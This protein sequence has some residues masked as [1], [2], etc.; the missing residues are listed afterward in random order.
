M[1]ATDR[2]RVPSQFPGV[3]SD[4]LRAD[5]YST[6]AKLGTIECGRILSVAPQRGRATATEAFGPGSCQLVI[7]GGYW[8]TDAADPAVRVPLTTGLTIQVYITDAALAVRG[9]GAYPRWRRAVPRFVGTITD[10]GDVDIRP[11]NP[12][13][14]LC[15]I[16]C[17]TARARFGNAPEW[18]LFDT[19]VALEVLEADTDRDLLDR[20]LDQTYAMDP[21]IGA[22]TA[23]AASTPDT[24]PGKPAIGNPAL[25]PV[26]ATLPLIPMTNL[27]AGYDE[28]EGKTI[29]DVL[30]DLEPATGG[31]FF[32]SRRGQF[33]WLIPEE[34]RNAGAPLVIDPHWCQTPLTVRQG[35]GDVVNRQ[36]IGFAVPAGFYYEDS[37]PESIADRGHLPGAQV[38]TR[39]QAT[40]FGTDDVGLTR[41]L[42][43]A[44]G[45]VG[46]YSV[47]AWTTPAVTIDLTR[48][49]EAGEDTL[50]LDLLSLDVASLVQLDALPRRFPGDPG[51]YWVEGQAE[52]ITSGRWLMTLS[53]VPY[54]LLS[55]GTRWD[56]L[57]ADLTW[58]D[59]PAE[60]TW[61]RAY[62][63]NPD[64]YP[65]G[66][67]KSQPSDLRWRNVSSTATW[68]TY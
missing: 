62:A 42:N 38:S 32:E 22:L 45:V 25:V 31:V 3:E 60:L 57:P 20:A 33:R 10:L 56:D 54:A 30:N 36:R 29:V 47:P 16:T 40:T 28:Y 65:V 52:A 21:S 7:A 49:L 64:P 14:L 27:A 6:T 1:A 12:D 43:L 19:P 35:I 63:Y 5:V 61:I 59:V 51:V 13:T 44:F 34:R 26:T 48:V 23:V 55:P 58:N 39:L 24:Y 11:G 17:T 2:N 9:S 18:R 37:D 50:F 8:F 53:L 46:R 66:A 41:G 4:W 67:W 68:N 15:P